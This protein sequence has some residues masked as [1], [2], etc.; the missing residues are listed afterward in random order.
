MFNKEC[1]ALFRPTPTHDIEFVDEN[2]GIQKRA[3]L[4]ILAVDSHPNLFVETLIDNW[5]LKVPDI[6]VSV[7][8]TLNHVNLRHEEFSAFQSGLVKVVSTTKCWVITGGTNDGA[9]ELVSRALK[10]VQYLKWLG[11]NEMNFDLIGVTNWNCLAENR[12]MS[13]FWSGDSLMTPTEGHLRIP[14]PVAPPQKRTLIK[15]LSDPLRSRRSVKKATST[16][17]IAPKDKTFKYFVKKTRSKATPARSVN[18]SSSNLTDNAIAASTYDRYETHLNPIFTHFVAIESAVREKHCELPARIQIENF[19]SKDK[20]S[21]ASNAEVEDL[22]LLNTPTVL[23]VFGGDAKTLEHMARS[24]E[25]GIPVVLCQG[26]GGIVDY[27][28]LLLHKVPPSNDASKWFVI[29]R[30]LDFFIIAPQ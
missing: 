19:C 26:S 23:L 17:S 15:T 7:T 12:T 28:I 6:I 1:F 5:G 8:G 4:S 18:V 16:E 29:I 24:V 9:D 22:K 3:Q 25:N 27:L 30:I 13:S 21:F 10:E 2:E 20:A 11:K 14:V